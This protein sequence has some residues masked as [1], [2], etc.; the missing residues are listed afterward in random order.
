[1]VSTLDPITGLPEGQVYVPQYQLPLAS[2]PVNLSEL[3]AQGKQSQWLYPDNIPPVLARL[4]ARDLTNPGNAQD[5]S[6]DGKR[7]LNVDIAAIS[8]G[9]NIG[10]GGALGVPTTATYDWS[11][12]RGVG[13]AQTD[14]GDLLYK[15][16]KL[17][18]WKAWVRYYPTWA[19]AN[20][21]GEFVANVKA[22][23]ASQM[24][25]QMI[26]NCW[27]TGST[28]ESNFLTFTEELFIPGGFD[29][30][31]PTHDQSNTLRVVAQ[32]EHGAVVTFGADISWV[33]LYD[34]Q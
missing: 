6:T 19:T 20:T 28:V 32:V 14:C 24:L 25:F 5:L 3:N 17:Y 11:P 33:M 31:G 12:P 13:A 9:V 7:N 16:K 4:Q 21:A 8:P 26:N 34:P 18:Y 30:T 23:G 22:Y 27:Q 1:M 10:G 15:I 29:L 2:Q